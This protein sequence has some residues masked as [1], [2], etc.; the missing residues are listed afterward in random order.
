MGELKKEELLT[1]VKRK[2]RFYPTLVTHEIIPPAV[3]E[4]REDTDGNTYLR[5]I[6]F[7]SDQLLLIPG[8][9]VDMY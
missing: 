2:D 9:P 5:E 8:T 6:A 4:T 7:P 1:W 3:Y